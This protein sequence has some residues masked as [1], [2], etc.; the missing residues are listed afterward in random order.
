MLSHTQEPTC[1]VIL[2]TCNASKCALY[3]KGQKE[4]QWCIGHESLSNKGK[5]GLCGQ[6]KMFPILIVVLT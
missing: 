4:D 3:F 1:C 6:I 2:L 5:R